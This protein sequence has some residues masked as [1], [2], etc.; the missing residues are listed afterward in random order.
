VADEDLRN[1]DFAG[2]SDERVDDVRPFENFDDCSDLP[3]N[4]EVSFERGFVFL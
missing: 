1:A 3:R 2:K 4:I